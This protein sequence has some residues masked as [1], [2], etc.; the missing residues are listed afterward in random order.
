[1][2]GYRGHKKQHRLDIHLENF[3]SIL[4]RV[5]DIWA[6]HIQPFWQAKD[7]PKRSKTS[8]TVVEPIFTGDSHHKLGSLNG[9]NRLPNDRSLPTPV[10]R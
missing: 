4:S 7:V 8:I 10:A 5:H 9:T 2:T 3:P 6:Q 1:M